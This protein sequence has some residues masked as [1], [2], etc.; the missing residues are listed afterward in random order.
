ME[1]LKSG[2]LDKYSLRAW[3]ATSHSSVHWKACFSV[4]KNGW[5]LSMALEMN[6]FKATIRLVNL[7]TS[8]TLLGEVISSMAF[9]FSRLA[10][11]PCWETMNPKNLPNETPNTHFTKFN[12]I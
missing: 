7:Y 6:L 5:H 1:K 9:T 10:S 8:F 12:L 11:I 3:K 4:L 2:G